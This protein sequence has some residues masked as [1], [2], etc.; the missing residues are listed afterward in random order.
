MD[1]YNISDEL[2]FTGKIRKICAGHSTLPSYLLEELMKGLV[3]RGTLSIVKQHVQI[4]LP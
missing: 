4:T 2:Y 3:D 1:K